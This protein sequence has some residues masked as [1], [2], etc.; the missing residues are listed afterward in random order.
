M[1]VVP[2]SQTVS[3]PV[4]QMRKNKVHDNPSVKIRCRDGN[5]EYYKH[6]NIIMTNRNT[7]D[8]EMRCHTVSLN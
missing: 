2:C 6:I 5:N 8:S 4:L 7:K 1:Y 3:S